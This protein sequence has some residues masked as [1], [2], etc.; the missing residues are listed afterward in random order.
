MEIV[1]SGCFPSSTEIHM[2]R[3]CQVMVAKVHSLLAN[4]I[5]ESS[6]SVIIIAQKVSTNRKRQASFSDRYRDP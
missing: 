6:Y 1:C 2:H 5:S 4:E 3:L